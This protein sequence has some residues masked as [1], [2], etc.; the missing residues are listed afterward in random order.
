M[1]SNDWHKGADDGKQ[2]QLV[3][4]TIEIYKNTSFYVFISIGDHLR[5]LDPRVLWAR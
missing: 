5:I 2:G 3:Q 1:N 4:E